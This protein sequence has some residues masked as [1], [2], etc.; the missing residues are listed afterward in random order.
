MFPPGS[1]SLFHSKVLT[2]ARKDIRWMRV[3]DI[4]SGQKLVLYNHSDRNIVKTG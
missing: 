4:Y 2:N 3:E 1:A